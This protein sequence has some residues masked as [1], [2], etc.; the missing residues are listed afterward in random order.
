M[1]RTMKMLLFFV[2]TAGLVLGACTP[3]TPVVVEKE[4][5]KTVVVE[6]TRV[7][8]VEKAV[9][10][11]PVV[12]AWGVVMPP[13]AAP[14]DKQVL[15]LPCQ[16]NK[17]MEVMASFYDGNKSCGGVWLWERLVM[18]DENSQVV[19][20]AADKWEMSEDGNSWIFHIRE[21]AKWSDG[22]P[23]TA[24]D[25]VYSLKRQLDPKTGSTWSWFY[26]DIKNASAV[27][28]GT[29]PPDEL[30]IKALDE[31][32]VVVETN[33]KIPY[34]PQLMAYPSSAPVPVKMVEQYGDAWSNDP[35]TALSNGPWMLTEYTPG[36]QIVL[37]P[38]PNYVGEHKPLIQ[39]FILKPSTGDNFPAYQ[40][41]E[42]DGLFDDQDTTPITGPNYRLVISDPRLM[43]ELYAYPY[44]ATRYLFFDTTVKPWDDIRVRQAIAHAVDRDTLLQVIYAGL[45]APAV[46]MLPP[47]FPAYVEGELDQYQ[48]FDLELAKKLLSDAGYPDGQGFPEVELWYNNGDADRVKTAEILQQMLKENLGINVK[49][50]PVESKVFRETFNEGKVDFGVHNWEF[51]Y[52]DPSNFLNVWDPNLGRHKEWNNAKFNELVEVAATE[53][54][55]AKRIQMYEEANKLLSEEAAGVFLYHWGHAQMWKSYVGGLS[56]DTLG[57][58]R[59]PYYYLGMHK[60]YIKAQ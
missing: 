17:Y 47:G 56:K 23:L 21:G 37:E 8:E 57:Y 41:G 60:V 6:Q 45:G 7:V 14:L 30:G 59:V 26:G 5:E 53:S 13:D 15:T 52:I 3:A 20:G 16:E 58:M 48:Q 55:S 28:E 4:V 42:V 32:T 34:L 27:S 46:G 54:D 35:K 33:G 49:L 43:R 25:F 18:L 40:A 38:N 19:P 2:I 44:F 12:N 11:E 22:S 29:V 51:D 39:K 31:K 1:K 10:P 36:K 50:S 9:T 24:E